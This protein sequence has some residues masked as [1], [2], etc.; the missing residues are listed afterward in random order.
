[1]STPSKHFKDELQDLL[2][3]RLDPAVRAEVEKHL[4]TCAECRR[5][6]A[7]LAWAR[8]TAGRLPEVE[9]PAGLREKILKSIRAEQV[10]P[11]AETV[12]RAFWRRHLQPLLAAAALVVL[13]A[14]LVNGN[15][16]KRE[17]L[18]EIA[19]ND[20]RAYQ[21]QQLSL[22]LDTADLAA[23]EAFFAE[24]GV[25]FRTR[26]LDLGM[27]RFHLV[28][29]RVLEPGSK[30]RALFVYRGPANEKLVCQMYLGDVGEL[31]DGGT[32]RENNGIPFHV[33]RKGDL[34]AVFW[35]EGAVMCVLVSDM[36]PE[37]VVQLAFA[38]AMP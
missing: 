18:P 16:L 8:Q 17:P 10:E 23:M 21:A 12:Q 14:I 34:T 1:M 26:V 25:P 36:D 24:H 29:G 19:M 6:I 31:P 38:K 33:F 7:A 22:D 4:E 20:F 27:M 13:T 3:Q 30:V 2:D 9:A 37:Q 35:P 5:E 32:V 11:E 15:F 28:G